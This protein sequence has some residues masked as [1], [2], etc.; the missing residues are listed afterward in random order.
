MAFGEGGLAPIRAPFTAAGRL[1]GLSPA[2][3]APVGRFA[4]AARMGRNA[5]ILGTGIMGTQQ[6]INGGMGVADD[7]LASRMPQVRDNMAQFADEYIG[8]RLPALQDSVNE[9]LSNLGLLGADGR[10]NPLAGVGQRLG[11]G[12]DA[13]FR[14]LGMDP[15]R[16]SPLQKMMVLGGAGVGGIGAAAGSPVMAGMGGVGAMAGLLPQFMP[17]QG[18][19][20]LNQQYM[21]GQQPPGGQPGQPQGPNTP[22][23]NT[24]QARNEWLLQQQQQGG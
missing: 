24:P 15:S 23:P 3:A 19:Q 11:G 1:A 9:H 20:R 5:G 4:N 21:P 2:G 10:F 17:G 22:P 14:G 18:Q 6:L 7:Y 13:I 16:M 8:S 12:V